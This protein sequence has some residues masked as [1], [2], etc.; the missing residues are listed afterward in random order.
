MNNIYFFLLGSIIFEVYNS[1][2]DH[3]RSV[4]MSLLCDYSFYIAIVYVVNSFH[5]CILVLRNK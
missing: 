4:V 2:T 5:I 3:V 1:L